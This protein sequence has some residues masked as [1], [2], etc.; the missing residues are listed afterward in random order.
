MAPDVS[1]VDNVFDFMQRGVFDIFKSFSAGPQPDVNITYPS[2]LPADNRQQSEVPDSTVITPD[3]AAAVEVVKTIKS[4]MRRPTFL[5]IITMY[6]QP[7]LTLA[8]YDHVVALMKDADSE[9]TLPSSTTLRQHIFPKLLR[10]NF[11]TSSITNFGAHSPSEQQ[12]DQQ[13]KQQDSSS[14]HPSGKKKNEAV[15]VLLSSWAKFDIRSLHVLREIVCVQSCRCAPK[16]GESDLRIETTPAVHAKSTLSTKSDFLWTNNN[17]V[18][19]PATTDCSIR[20]HFASQPEDIPSFRDVAPERAAFRGEPFHAITAFVIATEHVVH[21]TDGSTSIEH[22]L[23]PSQVTFSIHQLYTDVLAH[24]GNLCQDRAERNEDDNSTREEQRSPAHTNEDSLHLLPGDHLTFLSTNTSTS[25]I[26]LVSR[27]WVVRLSDERSFAIIFS[28][29]SRA[30]LQTT[31]LTTLGAPTLLSPPDQQAHQQPT[32]HKCY[33]QGKL[34]YG[35]Q[36]YKYRILLYAD[37]FTP[38][39]TLFPKGSVGGFYMSPSGFS[40]RSRSSQLTI[41]AISLTPSGVS[42]NLVFEDI[43]KDIVDG[44]VS[45]V[46]AVDAYG[47]DV[48]IFLE[49]TGFVGDYPAS[50]AVVDVKGHTSSSPCTHCTFPRKMVLGSSMYA[51]STVFHSGHSAYRRSQRRSFSARAF[52]LSDRVAKNLGMKPYNSAGIDQKGKQVL[53]KLAAALNSA[54]STNDRVFEELGIHRLDSYE[55]NIVAPEHLI[56]GLFKGLLTLCYIHISDE[57]IRR[58]LTILIRS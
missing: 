58:K 12:D 45:G 8:A 36:Y 31:R 29:N 57:V 14:P 22:G 27:F 25:I 40:I 43:I 28:C 32:S 33:T 23:L 42:T 30:E 2:V 50:S 19:T 37:D 9:N 18:P 16:L 6:G 55:A 15:I 24:L 3:R 53:L 5:G 4:F 46:D 21:S 7:R 47:N 17:G 13:D 34:P 41:R 54:I 38:R 11:V 52:G 44:S 35:R 20:L 1:N 26:V 56:T 48:T 39:S 51:Y 49:V 10:E